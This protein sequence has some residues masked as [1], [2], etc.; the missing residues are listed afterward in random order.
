[1]VKRIDQNKR[2]CLIWMDQVQPRQ[3][4]YA[5]QVRLD[6]GSNSWPLDHDS[7]LN[8]TEMNAITTCPSVT[9]VSHFGLHMT[10]HDKKDRSKQE[11]IFIS[12]HILLNHAHLNL[13]I[14]LRSMS[15]SLSDII[16]CNMSYVTMICG[17][18]SNWS[19]PLEVPHY[20]LLIL[21]NPC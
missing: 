12:C 5:S 9:S 13:L 6:R 19:Y 4:C 10:E 2:P 11:A 21:N 16:S 17:L 8:V 20:L 3:K 1:M 14:I 18:W 7:T 15:Q